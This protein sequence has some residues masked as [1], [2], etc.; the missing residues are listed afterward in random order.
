MPEYRFSYYR[1]KTR[2]TRGF[3]AD[4]D[5]DARQKIRRFIKMFTVKY[6]EKSMVV[7][8]RDSPRFAPL[9]DDQFLQAA[10]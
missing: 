10:E 2:L 4:T 9:P 1:G 5:K 3:R 6:V 8:R 7:C